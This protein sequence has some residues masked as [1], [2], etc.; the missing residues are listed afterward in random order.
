MMVG[1]GL[2]GALGI[3]LCL[4]LAGSRGSSCTSDICMILCYEVALFPAV[5]VYFMNYVF[6]EGFY[7]FPIYY[8]C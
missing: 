3:L 4:N 7:V 8:Q 1:G 2:P 5:D 6:Y